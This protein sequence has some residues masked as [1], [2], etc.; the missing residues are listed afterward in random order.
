MSETG[1]RN[2]IRIDD[3]EQPIFRIYSKERFLRGVAKGRDALRNPSCWHDPFENFFL[4][5]TQVAV[6]G[7]LADLKTVARDWYGQCWTTNSNTDAM[8]RIY[9]PNQTGI[10][11]KTTIRKL[12]KNLRSVPSETPQLQFFVGRVEYMCQAE[13]TA[14]LN[15]LTFYDAA[16]GGQGHSFAKLLCIKR[17]AFRHEAEIRILFQDID[18]PPQGVNGIFVYPLDANA[19]FDEIV[20]DPR[21]QDA[22]ATELESELRAAGCTTPIQRSD[23][24]TAPHFVIPAQ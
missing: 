5:R 18:D 22:A 21:L 2:I 20:L 10:Q 9:S 1:D 13:I 3:L 8:W 17:E 7:D 14:L 19:V 6:N 12:F 11:A 16:S 24:Y 23:L 15:T 4:T